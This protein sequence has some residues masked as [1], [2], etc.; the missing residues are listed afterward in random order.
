[1]P[2]RNV[3]RGLHIASWRHPDAQD[4]AQE[5]AQEDAG[6]NFPRVAPASE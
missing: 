4:D 2:E 6:V 1:M 5:D 3:Q